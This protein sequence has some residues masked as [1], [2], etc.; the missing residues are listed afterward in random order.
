MGILLA[1][2]SSA[3]WGTSDFYGGTLTRRRPAVTVAAVSELIGLTCVLI[4]AIATGAVTSSHGYLVWGLL[5]AVAGTAGVVAFYEALATGTM[6]IVAPIAA[7]GVV[8]PVVVGFIQGDRP[9][10]W[11]IAG[12]VVAVIGIIFASGPELQ[13]EGD[14]SGAARP[15]W[16]A[17]IAAVAFGVVFVAIGHGAEHSTLMTL[18]VM[19]AVAVAFMVGIALATSTSLRVDRTDAPMLLTVGVFDVGANATFAYASRHGLLS[20]ISVLGSL[21]PAMTVV[22]ARAVHSERLA[23]VQL[24]GVVG[25][26][27]GVVLIAS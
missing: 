16:L 25:A 26:L 2:A 5:G 8:V 10:G 11:Q 23:K 3:L 20:V 9:S 18:V 21:Y 7:T 1:L 17:G 15:L 27:A 6:G 22:L 12:I 4:A 19:R 14:R 13:R 24:F